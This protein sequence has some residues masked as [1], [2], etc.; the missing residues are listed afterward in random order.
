MKK[1]ALF[2]IFFVFISSVL[3]CHELS[4][5]SHKNTEVIAQNWLAVINKIP[6]KDRIIEYQLAFKEEIKSGDNLIAHVYHLAPGGHILVTPYRELNPIKSF[7]FMSNFDIES[8]RYE[9]AVIE[10]L[11]A[12]VSF[13]SSYEKGSIEQIDDAIKSNKEEWKKSLALRLATASVQENEIEGIDGNQQILKYTLKDEIGNILQLTNAVPLLETKWAQSEPYW[14]LC[15]L[16]NGKRSLVGCVATAMAQIMR[17][18][19]WPKK[20][21]GSYSY[22]WWDGG[23]T[24]T[25]NFSDSYDWDH[26]PNLTSQY[27]SK[28]KQDAVSELCYEAG[29]S[30]EMEYSPESSGAFTYDVPRALSYYFR[31]QYYPKLIYRYNFYYSDWISKLKRQ[32][33][34]MRPVLLAIRNYSNEG[35]AVVMDGYVGNMFHINMGWDGY[36]D[37]YYYVDNIDQFTNAYLTRALIDIIPDAAVIKLNKTSISISRLE[38]TSNPLP[39]YFKISNTGTLYPW[40]Y[41]NLLSKF[42]VELFS[43]RFGLKCRSLS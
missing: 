31:Y 32:R 29:V 40:K 42:L 4:I 1:T 35:H 43:H 38:G 36:K 9:K 22:Y 2:T 6:F 8:D 24:L 34:L 18:Y 23:K 13:L 12:I 25:A 10:E 7:S 37:A 26:M 19:K 3:I 41:Q 27:D 5:V 17:Y 21:T 14:N 16:L 15:P 11:S 20:G 28:L 39:R 33:D 30:V